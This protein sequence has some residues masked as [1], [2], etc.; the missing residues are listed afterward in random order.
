MMQGFRDF[1]DFFLIHF[2]LLTCDC[3]WVWDLKEK[4]FRHLKTPE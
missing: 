1:T 4:K 3:E 2:L